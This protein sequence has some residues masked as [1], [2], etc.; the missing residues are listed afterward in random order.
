M[1]PLN[2]TPA[3][4]FF[5][6]EEQA[7]ECKRQCDWLGILICVLRGERIDYVLMNELRVAMC[8][9]VRT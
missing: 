7:D 1:C 3:E 2:L 4:T 9:R 6:A 5:D 8:E